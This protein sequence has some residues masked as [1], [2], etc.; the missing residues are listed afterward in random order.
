MKWF[1]TTVMDI[2]ECFSIKVNPTFI[3]CKR[4]GILDH[5]SSVH[6]HLCTIWQH[7]SFILAF[8]CILI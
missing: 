5:S 6:I 8:S 3:T 7:H 1:A 4:R 2:K